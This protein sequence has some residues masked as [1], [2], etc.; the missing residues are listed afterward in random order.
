MARLA[1]SFSAKSAEGEVFK[2]LVYQDE[3]TVQTRRGVMSDPGMRSLRLESGE[4][5][6][7]IDRGVYELPMRGHERLTSDDPMAV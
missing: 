2:I 5:V 3:I 1:S 4:A 6:N 7:R